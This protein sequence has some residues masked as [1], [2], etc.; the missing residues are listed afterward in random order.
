MTAADL[1]GVRDY[2]DCQPAR[3]DPFAFDARERRAE[4]TL[5]DY[6]EL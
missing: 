5:S 1:A 6:T 4:G 2:S 3:V